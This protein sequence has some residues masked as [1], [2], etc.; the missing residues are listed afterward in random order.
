MKMSELYNFLSVLRNVLG[1][2]SA[3]RM[4]SDLLVKGTECI[5]SI[6]AVLLF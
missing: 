3:L 5:V 6:T 2:H 1:A 4:I